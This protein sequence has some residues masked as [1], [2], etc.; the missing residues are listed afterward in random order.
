[1]KPT[2]T[3]RELQSTTLGLAAAGLGALRPA[4][5]LAAPREQL[6][7]APTVVSR[8]MA[9]VHTAVYDAW[10][11]YDA[12]AIGTRL[13]GDLRRPSWERTLANKQEAI[14]Y[15]AYRALV[16]LFPA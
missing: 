13:G 10:A 4:A 14:S 3:R 9:M 11:A 16:D 8:A 1:M 2:F 5:A 7:P 6:V 15:A 12:T